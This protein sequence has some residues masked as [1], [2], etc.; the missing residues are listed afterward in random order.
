MAFD[1]NMRASDADRDRVASLLREHHA[2]GRLTAEEFDERLGQT[3]TAVTVGQLDRLLADLPSID[4]YR[5]PDAAL[6]RQPR[7]AQRPA[8]RR[9]RSA[10]WQA[11]WGSWFTVTVL[12]FI[13]WL[14]AGGG[15]FWPIW[16]ALPF[17]ACLGVGWLASTAI[18]GGSSHDSI[19]GDP[20]HQQLPR[21]DDDLPGRPGR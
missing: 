5:L 9:G 15:Y 2:A 11:A 12:C 16:V 3:F 13:I 17:G 6:T 4:L 1:P 20:G 14:L 10:G 19:S 8:R 7:Q 18:G 21:P